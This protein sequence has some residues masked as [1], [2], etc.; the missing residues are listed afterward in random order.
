MVPLQLRGHHFLCMLTF[1]GKGYTPHFTE[2]MKRV[3]ADVSEGR[4]VRLKRGPDDICSG[5]L[6]SACGP[7]GRHCRYPWVSLRDMIAA[8]A[9]STVLKRDLEQPFSLT[10]ADLFV[11]RDE[12]TNGTIRKACRFCQWSSFCDEVADQGFENSLLKVEGDVNP[13]I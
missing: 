9:V 3:I 11:L 2:N 8:K 6:S 4:P 7:F 13:K 5:L 12:F 10:A 1:V